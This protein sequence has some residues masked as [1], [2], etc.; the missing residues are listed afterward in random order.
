[1]ALTAEMVTID[2][3]DPRALAGFWEKALDMRVAQDFGGEFV[4]LK[5][6][7]PLQLCLQKVG[8]PRVGKNRVHLDL[9]AHGD[10]HD[11]VD[12][13]IG[14]GARAIEEHEIPGYAWTVLADPDGNEFCVGAPQAQHD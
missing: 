4:V 6:D 5:G 3:A 8:E 2:C 11:E 10:P 7:G 9:L 14:L 13:L 1:M 12:R